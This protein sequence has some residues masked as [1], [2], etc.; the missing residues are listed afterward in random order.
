MEV[1][2]SVPSTN[3]LRQNDH[4]VRLVLSQDELVT[5]LILCMA[6]SYLPK[7]GSIIGLILHTSW[8]RLKEDN[9]S[10]ELVVAI[11][12]P[13][14]K[15]SPNSSDFRISR[16]PRPFRIDSRG[17][18][19][20]LVL[21]AQ[22]EVQFLIAW[23]EL[24]GEKNGSTDTSP[25]MRLDDLLFKKLQSLDLGIWNPS[26]LPVTREERQLLVLRDQVILVRWPLLSVKHGRKVVHSHVYM[27]KPFL[28]ARLFVLTLVEKWNVHIEA[29]GA[30][31]LPVHLHF[32]VCFLR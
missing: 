10:V 28:F 4:L 19:M 11:L 6:I 17:I 16:F 22:L 2:E 23:V 18:K 13:F 27:S 14:S 7:A 32:E 25:P 26:S 31:L 15:K 3:E 5:N 20:H 8:F 9:L 24:T 12:N 30:L 1:V 29:E 21:R